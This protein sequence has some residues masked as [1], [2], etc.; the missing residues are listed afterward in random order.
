MFI[1]GFYV[2]KVIKFY[3][4]NMKSKAILVS[5]IALFVLAFA[6]TSV[7]ASDFVNVTDVEVN[8]IS[9]ILDDVD[10]AIGVEVSETIPIVVKFT[11]LEDTDDVRVKAY[12][13]GYKSEI[14][15]ETSRF[16]ILEG[17]T[18]VKRFSLRLPSS[19]DLDDLSEE[20]RLLVRVSA[21]SQES[22]EV[23]VPLE[24]QKGSYSFNLLSIDSPEV[25][26]SGDRIAVDV[27]L[28]NN[29][30]E[31]L[32]N[33]YVKAT[34]PGLGI[35]QRVYVGD[36][37]PNVDEY[38]D[39]INDAIM[40][41]LY[42]TVPRD[43]VPGNYEMEVEAYNYDT[44]VIA[45]SRVVVRDVEAGVIPSSTSRTIA[46][47]EEASFNLV[48]VNPSDRMV[49]YTI[50]PEESKGVLVEVTEPVVTVGADSSRTVQILARAT[51]DADE[52]TYVVTVNAIS[53]AGMSKQV[54]FSVNVEKSSSSGITG[55]VVG[56]NAN[57]AVVLTV[58]LV[59]VFVVLLIVLI[60]LLTKR[61]AEQSEEFGETNYY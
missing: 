27:V 28:E 51:K 1:K 21:K 44:S 23:Y 3:I 22:E 39:D 52:G 50:T 59:I 9:V 42:L 14:S 8:G 43:A 12:I 20:L 19:L 55:S 17:N 10:Q 31:R 49:V 60:V 41:R 54:S 26:Y 24:V 13:E 38:D 40:K 45:V 36:L 2:L 48:L 56:G 47:G 33:A 4:S 32:D 25:V 37:A 11:A 6:V 30:N 34:V 5:M 53:E 46:P 18:Y 58:I 7:I 29:G 15:E 35:S 57:T 16:H 61:P